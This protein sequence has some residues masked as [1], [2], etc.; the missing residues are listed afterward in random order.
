MTGLARM[1]DPHPM[2]QLMMR[3]AEEFFLLKNVLRTLQLQSHSQ[4]HGTRRGK[5]PWDK[6]MAPY[7]SQKNRTIRDKSGHIHQPRRAVEQSIQESPHHTGTSVLRCLMGTINQQSIE[8]AGQEHGHAQTGCPHEQH[9]PSSESVDCQGGDDGSDDAGCVG[10]GTEPSGLSL[11]VAGLP[12]DI[13][14]VDRHGRDA[15]P[16]HHDLQP[17]RKIG[18][19]RQ[20]QLARGTPKKQ[21]QEI[22]LLLHRFL[23]PH[24]LDDVLVF[25]LHVFRIGCISTSQGLEDLQRLFVAAFFDEPPW[26]FGQ[27]PD[28]K[29][30]DG[31]RQALEGQTEPPSKAGADGG[32]SGVAQAKGEPI[33]D[34][35]ADVVGQEDQTD[36]ST[37][38]LSTD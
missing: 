28:G 26:R 29:G 33:R 35:D 15:V 27:E 34:R 16:L 30:Q 19:Q 9:F 21:F 10:E 5:S 24:H 18:P 2:A 25:S 11:V 36:K 1:E 3:L 37:C 32:I 38:L 20:M 8:P 4:K 13:R 12:V 14:G 6:Q 23:R 7:K 31:G 17:E 22:A